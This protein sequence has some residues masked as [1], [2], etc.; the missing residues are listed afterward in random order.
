MSTP[1]AGSSAYAP[2]TSS[3]TSS[4]TAEIS[5]AGTS[6]SSSSSTWSTSR[7][8]PPPSRRRRRVD[9][10]AEDDRVA[11]HRLGEDVREDAQLDLGVV[12]G[13]EA[14]ALLGDDGRADLA[15][16]LGAD[17]SRLQI[18]LRGREAAGRRDGLV[19]GR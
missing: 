11:M 4:P 5:P 1:S 10:H 6:R 12:G 18:R 17:R 19:E 2:H 16:E 7:A 15:A 8:A 3:R 13:E 9:G 14:A